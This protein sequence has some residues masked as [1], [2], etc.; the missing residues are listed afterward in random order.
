MNCKNNCISIIWHNLELVLCLSN[1][2]EE[3]GQIH[4][5][6]YVSPD[7]KQPLLLLS[8][9]NINC[10]EIKISSHFFASSLAQNRKLVEILV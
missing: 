4:R 5:L 10:T 9:L 3:D 7:Y 8:T 1:Q 6:R 2:I